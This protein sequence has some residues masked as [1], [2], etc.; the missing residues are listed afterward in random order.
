VDTDVSLAALVPA[1]QQLNRELPT[2]AVVVL[3]H[4]RGD[5]ELY[6]AIEA[7]AAAHVLDTVQP[8][9]LVRTIR[10]VAAGDYVIDASVA[11]RPEVA[12][13][14][15]EVFRSSAVGG[16]QAGAATAGHV[17][18]PLS[19]REAQILTLISEGKANKESPR[20]CSSA[21]TR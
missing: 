6:R 19:V 13:R 20:H 18:E 9:E 2:T 7:G 3:G 10:A 16:H 5:D 8:A 12:R 14:V 1:L 17:V 15:L 21:A 11:A 4:H